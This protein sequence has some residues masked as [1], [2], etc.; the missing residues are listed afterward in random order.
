MAGGARTDGGGARALAPLR[1]SA[2][3]LYL[4]TLAAGLPAP[5]GVDFDDH[6]ELTDGPR[7]STLLEVRARLHHRGLLGAGNRP[8]PHVATV[9][10]A[11]CDPLVRVDV[12][13][14]LPPAPTIDLTFTTRGDVAVAIEVD[15][16]GGGVHLQPF[17]ARDLVARVQ[18]AA[19][20]AR[21]PKPEVG[22]ITLPIDVA[23]QAAAGARSTGDVQAVVVAALGAQGAPSDAAAVLARAVTSA[24]SWNLVAVTTRDEGQVTEVAWLDGG[25][26]GL[27]STTP[28]DDTGD[29]VLEPISAVGI[30]RRIQEAVPAP[31][32]LPPP[33]RAR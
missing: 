10:T 7:S 29:I 32:A 15:A 5:A 21:R 26:A 9:L 31:G 4:L 1:L 17:D 28:V 23:Q 16:G 27:W 18:A 2:A 33:R 6:P 19:A 11:A 24:A 20:I 13:R 8:E 22:P 30:L 14:E 3:E 25:S 12:E